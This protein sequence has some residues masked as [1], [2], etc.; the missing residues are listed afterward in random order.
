MNTYYIYYIT[1]N[2]CGDLNFRVYH[3]LSSTEKNAS[4]QPAMINMLYSTTICLLNKCI[5]NTKYLYIIEYS[6]L[7]DQQ[8]VDFPENGSHSLENRFND[9]HM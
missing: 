5:H 7:K 4:P 8:G 6:S 3:F 9:Y 2:V 1:K